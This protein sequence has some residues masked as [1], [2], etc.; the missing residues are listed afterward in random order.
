MCLST[1]IYLQQNLIVTH[2]SKHLCYLLS[3]FPSHIFSHISVAADII[4]CGTGKVHFL[5][6]IS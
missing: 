1:W 3:M 2:H 6:K 4:Q 5:T